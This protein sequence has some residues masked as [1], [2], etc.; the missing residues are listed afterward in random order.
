MEQRHSGLPF[1]DIRNLIDTLPPANE[2]AR[3]HTREQFPLELRDSSNKVGQL[4]EWYSLWSGR[5]PVVHRPLLTLFA[6][7]HALQNELD[8]GANNEW[9]LHTVTQVAEGN[10]TANRLCHQYD[11]GLKLFDLALQL[12]VEDISTDAALDEKSCAGTIAFGMEAIA[13]GSDLLSL[14]AIEQ[15]LNPSNL[16]IFS[17]L[18]DL[19]IEE[20]VGESSDF[21]PEGIGRMKAACELAKPHVKDSLE[22][23]RRL[24][25]RETAAICGAILAARAEHVPVIVSGETALAACLVLAKQNP[26]AVSHCVLA[27]AFNNPVLDRVTESLG[28]LRVLDAPFSGVFGADNVVA[29]GLVKS[30]CKH[31]SAENQ[32]TSNS[33]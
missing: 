22:V 10:A 24:G 30:A 5:S 21:S 29:S 23:L 32:A 26:D 18:S 7:T 1:D 8:G 27:S 17:V 14:C 2:D 25:G 11:L 33:G 13:G 20:V 6:G 19:S 15:G 3:L 28:I 9:L 31:L 16:T 4:C 12:P